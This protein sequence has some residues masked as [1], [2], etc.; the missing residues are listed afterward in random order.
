MHYSYNIKVFNVWSI[1]P[2]LSFS[3]LQHGVYGDVSFIDQIL[4]SNDTAGT[5]GPGFALDRAQDIDAGASMLVYTKGFWFGATIDHL[6]A[7]NVSLHASNAQ[8][9]LKTSIYGGIDIRAKGK[10]LKPSDDMMTFAFLYKQQ[11][12]IRQ[13]DIG[14]YWYNYPMIIGIWYRGIPTVSSHR[15]EAVVFLIGLKTTSVNVGYSYDLTISNMLAHTKGSH[16]VSFT[17]KFALPKRP[18]KGAVPCPEF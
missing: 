13:L 16:E 2:G 6:L 9:P 15:G 3:Y 12:L 7:P 10:L 4:S 8:I 5:S 11:D 18:Q 1:R 17:Y 14:A